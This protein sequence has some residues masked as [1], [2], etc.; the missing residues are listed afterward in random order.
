[1]LRAIGS[2]AVPVHRES[3]FASLIH[4]LKDKRIV[5]LGEASHGTH[6]YY[7]FRRLISQTLLREHGFKFIAVEGDWPDAHRLHK[8]VQKGGTE[9]AKQVLL[10]NHRWPTWMWANEEIVR[11]AEWMKDYGPFGFF[12]LDVYSLFDSIHAIVSYLQNNHSELAEEVKK[13]YACFDPYEGDEISYARSLFQYPEG[14]RTEVLKNLR[15]LLEMRVWQVAHDG[16][17]LFSSQQNARIIVNAEAYYRAMLEGDKH[18]WNIRDTH[19]LETLD[20]LLE[21]SGE[22]AKAIV[23][24]HNTHVGDYRA[25]DMLNSGYV[26][27]GGLARQKYGADNVALVGFGSHEG[28][29]LAGSAWG[30][31]ERVM[32]L[33]PSQEGSYESYFHE[34]AH[35]K[36]WRQFYVLLQDHEDSPFKQILGHRA[37]GVVYDPRHEKRGNYVPTSL[38]KRYDAFVFVDRTHALKSLHARAVRGEFPETWPSGQ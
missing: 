6:E 21:R 9:N 2:E 4:A 12:G 34:V 19:M 16:E 33:P 1:L 24:A 28:E 20:R 8:Y 29:V 31:P 5:M 23:W 32:P 7:Q 35:H 15:Q 27:I 13:R 26:N 30:A 18:S 36:K 17:E 14:C 22:G 3:D 38:S 25:T 37:V 11:L 10:Q